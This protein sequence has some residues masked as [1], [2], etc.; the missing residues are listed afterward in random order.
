M[1]LADREVDNLACECQRYLI[2]FKYDDAKHSPEHPIVR[3]SS[4]SRLNY[5]NMF[6]S[7]G[8]STFTRTVEAF[9]SWYGSAFLEASLG[10]VIRRLC[11]DKVAIEVDPLRSSKT[12]G[13]EKNLEILV[14]WCREV[15]AHIYEARRECPMCV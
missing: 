10:P 14:Y 6:G 12:K 5:S 4:V 13:L 1:D 3:M 8:N 15:W 7:R 9:M 11:E 2:L